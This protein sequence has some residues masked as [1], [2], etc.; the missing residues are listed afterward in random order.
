M[1]PIYCNRTA[2]GLA[3]THPDDGR[4]AARRPVCPVFKAFFRTRR[5]RYTPTTRARDG[6][7]IRRLQVRVLPGHETPCSVHKNLAASSPGWC[8]ASPPSKRRQTR[9]DHR[10]QA[11]RSRGGQRTPA[12]ALAL[13]RTHGACGGRG[14]VGGSASTS[15]AL[16]TRS[17]PRLIPPTRS[18]VSEYATASL[19]PLQRAAF[20]LRVKRILGSS[21]APAL[22]SDNTPRT[23]LLP[24]TP[25]IPRTEKAA[26][27]CG[28]AALRL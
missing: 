7:L 15:P 1:C 18:K 25:T 22:R 12:L 20:V 21:K 27:P 3:A 6:L 19:K 5:T 4:R 2:T 13:R 14:G 23:H 26:W 8:S 24:G 11:A 28:K 16:G 17:Q 10:R 9:Q